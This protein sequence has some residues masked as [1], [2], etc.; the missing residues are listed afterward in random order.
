MIVWMS[1]R[2]SV[3]K[4]PPGF[5]IVSQ[6]PSTKIAAMEN[7][8]K[9]LFGVQ[10][11]PEVVHTPFGM[12]IL[13]NFL[14]QACQAQPNWTMV[15]IIEQAV[16]E[17]K[18]KIGSKR[19]ICALS[20][21]VDSSVAALLVHK[22]IGD[23]LTCIFVDHGLLRKGEGEQVRE[24]F[25][26]HFKLNIDYVRAENKFLKKLK[27]II[28]PEQKRK[29]IGE[30]FIRTFEEEERKIAKELDA[31]LYMLFLSAFNVLLFRLSSQEDIIVGTPMAARRHEDLQNIIGMFV[32]TL[33]RRNYPR[34]DKLFA[35][36]AAE[37]KQNTI[38][39]YEN[40]EYPFEDL[41]DSLAM[42]REARRNP[43]FDAVFNL[44]EERAYQFEVSETT[45]AKALV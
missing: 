41:V 17:A 20:G 3:E 37:V 4:T 15:S 28:D 5:E 16:Q 35:R 13:K 44:L 7:I 29:I 21:G 26:E 27:D 2:D 23:N 12:N 1:H 10:F 9:G 45:E 19:A 18:A 40:Q 32:N 30:E 25:E 22:A 34:G 42:P 43:L 24:I 36:C 14:Y 8:K 11:H 33:V 39:A 31:T 38:A 6:T